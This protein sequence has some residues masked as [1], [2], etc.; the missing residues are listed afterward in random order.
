MD[1]ED[2]CRIISVSR[3]TD[4][5][6]FYMEEFLERMKVSKAKIIAWWSKDYKNWI[7][8]YK[9]NKNI[10][11][12]FK[13]YFNFTINISNSYKYHE[14]LEK[15]NT[16]LEE[17][18]FQLQFLVDNFGVENVRHRFDPIVFWKDNKGN[19]KNN[20]KDFEYII[21]KTSG[22][23]LKS[24]T[25]SFCILYKNVV[26]RMNR[27]KLFLFD[28]HINDKISIIKELLEICKKHDIRIELCCDENLLSLYI[29]EN[30]DEKP[31]IGKSSCINIQPLEKDEKQ[32]NECNCTKTIDVGNY[33][34]QC[35]HSCLYCYAS[36]N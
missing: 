34:Y 35:N 9:E 22:I 36:C 26:K 30:P 7:R 16:T 20:L 24:V 3:R 28:P 4:I 12:K 23:G 29:E 14:S 32:R 27:R 31:F 1:I 18:L 10:F 33:E 21:S 11:N 15:L 17:R 19:I 2:L 13:H 5:P 6:A 25:V 8:I